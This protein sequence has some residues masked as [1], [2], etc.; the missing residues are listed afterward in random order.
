MLHMHAVHHYST[1][2]MKQAYDPVFHRN[3]NEGKKHAHGLGWRGAGIWSKS[4]PTLECFTAVPQPSSSRLKYL[5]SK[6]TSLREL[7]VGACSQVPRGL[8]LWPQ[9]SSIPWAEAWPRHFFVYTGWT[10]IPPHPKETRGRGC[11]PDLHLE[12]HNI[13]YFMARDTMI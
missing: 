1:Q 6:Y 7:I 10:A 12:T 4:C 13:L 11:L 2:P 3:L 8:W 5:P 9:L